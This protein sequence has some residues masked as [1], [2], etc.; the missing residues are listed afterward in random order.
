MAH[1]LTVTGG[2]SPPGTR[3]RVRPVAP[4]RRGEAYDEVAHAVALGHAVPL[5]V[6]NRWLPRHVVLVVG[7][8]DAGLTAYDPAS[9]G[10]V[11]ITRDAFDGGD[12]RVAGWSEPWFAV[13][14]A[15]RTAH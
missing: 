2:T 15:G 11:T 5:Y 1:E 10:P 3:H 8:D 9:G 6:G 7:R 14:P 4:R 13:L 12:L